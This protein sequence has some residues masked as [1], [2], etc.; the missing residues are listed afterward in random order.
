[1]SVLLDVT[2]VGDR[3]RMDR[4]GSQPR[5]TVTFHGN[6]VV[7]A[8]GASFDADPN[9]N[10]SVANFD[11]FSDASFGISF[12][13]S[14]A[15]CTG[16]PYEYLYSHNQNNS[17]DSDIVQDSAN[18]NVNIYM[19]CEEAGAGW[20]SRAGSILRFL[21]KDNSGT[22]DKHARF[23]YALHTAGNFDAITNRWIHVVLSV[24][25]TR[26][27][28]YIDGSAV[29]DSVYG[30]YSGD[31]TNRNVA[32]PHPGR[33]DSSG[34]IGFSMAEDIVLGTRGDGALDRHF[35]GRLAG[36]AV[37]SNAVT[38]TQAQCLFK[39]GEELLHH[40]SSINCLSNVRA[41]MCSVPLLRSFRDV[42]H[43][44]H[45]VT[46]PIGKLRPSSRGLEFD[47][48]AD[49]LTIQN[50][51]YY[52][53]SRTYSISLWMTKVECTQQP[54]EYVFSHH[55][56]SDPRIW[57]SNSFL[58]IYVGCE[59][60]GGGW[61]T[62]HGTIIRYNIRDKDGTEASFD[63]SLHRSDNFDAITSKWIHVVLHAKPATLGTFIDGRAIPKHEYG[64]FRSSSNNPARPDPTTLTSPLGQLDLQTDI[65][66]GSR[67]DRD[68]QRFFKGRLALVNVYNRAL[69]AMEAQC[70]FYAGD[71][72]L[73]TPSSGIFRNCS[74][75]P[76]AAN[77]MLID[78][79]PFT[80]TSG[81]NRSVQQ[82][83]GMSVS[84]QGAHFDGHD[85]YVTIATFPY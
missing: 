15:A 80:D 33:L 22:A 47:G 77:V 57:E 63:Y 43:Y 35:V 81:S 2:F 24:E 31:T 53:R 18:S 46:P 51:D 1:M 30:F 13:M 29:R 41:A 38:G 83:G 42:S 36:L 12:W 3:G 37:G 61:S 58:N 16:S 20:S 60:A 67:A 59:S 23:D 50:F 68:P 4:S 78:S 65:Y 32:H 10:I 39:D 55:H 5:R 27:I 11:Y 14:K 73:P 48:H 8:N 84:A 71:A 79:H 66:I 72:V 85:D 44:R 25:P 49:Y 62:A 76:S 75:V 56:D 52:S 40:S 82:H 26:I 19:A 74:Q 6:V 54:Y 17:K 34:L 69:S 9:T 70:L 28:T 7:D 21:L 64:F 45:R